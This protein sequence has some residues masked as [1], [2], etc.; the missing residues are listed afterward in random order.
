MAY[1]HI[2][3]LYKSQAILQFRECYALEKIHGTSAHISWKDGH[4]SLSSGGEKADRFAELFDLETLAAAFEAIGHPDVVVFG[5]AYGGKQQGQSWRYGKELKFV[6]FEVK[7]DETWL[8]VPNAADVVS[9]LGL[10]FVHYE[11]V[12]TDLPSLDAQRDAPSMQAIRNGMGDNKRREGV[13]LR[14]VTEF[15]DH[16]GNRII[17]K[18]KRD[19]ERE[20]KTPRQVIDP[21]RQVV[22]TQAGAIADEWVTPTRLAHVLDKIEGEKGIERMREVIASMVEDVRREASGEIVESREACAAIAR[23]TS[24]LFRKYLND[25]VGA[26]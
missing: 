20:T 24:E 23:K 16:R 8:S 13:V 26:V 15:R 25:Q 5:E 10:E 9:K 17:C 4:V 11:I 7:V 6:A 18:H 3:N 19:E 21:N 22:L 1:M 12:S 2:D 14:P